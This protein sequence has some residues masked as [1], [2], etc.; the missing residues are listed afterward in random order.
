[1]TEEPAKELTKEPTIFGTWLYEAK[2]LNVYTMK[3]KRPSIAF[4]ET[5]MKALANKGAVINWVR[6]QPTHAICEMGFDLDK[7]EKLRLFIQLV[8]EMEN[9]V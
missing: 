6:N 2:V 1:M 7:F 4:W 3:G 8:E 9:E 5:L